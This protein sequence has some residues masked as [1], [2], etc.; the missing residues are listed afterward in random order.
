[1]L[2][3]VPEAFL[4]R[5]MLKVV[6]EAVGLSFVALITVLLNDESEFLFEGHCIV[7]GAARL[8][9]LVSKLL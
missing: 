4:G 2:T 3:L 8:V 6:V 7:L 9:P 5:V 1:M